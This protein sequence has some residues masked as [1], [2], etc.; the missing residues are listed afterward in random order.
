MR[1]KVKVVL[2]YLPPDGSAQP[3]GPSDRPCRFP[4]SQPAERASR[5]TLPQELAER[6]VRARLAGERLHTRDWSP[7]ANRR[8]SLQLE[9]DRR[10]L[11]SANPASPPMTTRPIA[12][13]VSAWLP[14]SCWFCSTLMT[15]SS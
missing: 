9:S 10:R 1:R 5:D 3:R 6:P 4:A 15:A 8:S 2:A 14:C 13:K 7:C 11:S 12:A